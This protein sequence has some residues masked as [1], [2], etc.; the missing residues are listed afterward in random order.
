VSI[1]RPLAA[2]RSCS[3]PIADPPLWERSDCDAERV[4]NEIGP[5]KSKPQH[6][7]TQCGLSDLVDPRSV[8]KLAALYRE[9]EG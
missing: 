6:Q 8:I 9:C 3:P 7:P 4:A 1:R 2:C 5:E